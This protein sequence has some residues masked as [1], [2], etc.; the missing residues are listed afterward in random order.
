MAVQDCNVSEF[1]L[2][3]DIGD[4]IPAGIVNLT[5]TH[6]SGDSL[7]V[8][9]FSIGGAG[10][11]QGGWV[12]G[13]VSSVVSKVVFTSNNNG[14]V[15]AAVHH[16]AFALTPNTDNILIDIDRKIEPVVK[17]VVRGCTDP[18][19][20]NYN[21]NANEDDGSCIVVNDPIGHDNFVDVN[22]AHTV[23]EAILEAPDSTDPKYVPLKVE[24]GDKAV[25]DVTLHDITSN[26][27]YN[28]TSGGFSTKARRVDKAGKFVNV[29]KNSLAVNF[30]KI[31]ANTTY[32]FYIEPIGV[33]TKLAVEVPTKKNPLVL[34]RRVDT[35]ITLALASA[36]NSAYWTIPS[37]TVTFTDRPGKIPK[38][39]SRFKWPRDL[40]LVPEL[41]S[42]DMHGQPGYNYFELTATFTASPGGG[43]ATKSAGKTANAEVSNISTASTLS[44]DNLI[45]PAARLYDLTTTFSANV[46]TIKGLFKVDRFGS[47]NQA[48]TIAIDDIITLS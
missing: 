13:N 1:D 8:T 20:A 32:H 21:A 5:I 22:D 4:I 3:G 43:A 46:L 11:S 10:F 33:E 36:S 34:L 27:K 16:N 30:P 2:L 41:T 19:A 23:H 15:N 44:G 31:T 26:K 24:A 12:G 47:Y 48:Y 35:T 14:T 40:S 6:N 29:E 18:T 37:S 25:Y 42:A 45:I 7:A 28:F 9:E 38:A 17:E 39:T